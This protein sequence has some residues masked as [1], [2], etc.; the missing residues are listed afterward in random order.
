MKVYE[1]LCR[2][3]RG[4]VGIGEVVQVERLCRFM[5]GFVGI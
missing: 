2:Y 1:R 4:C 3:L 5:R